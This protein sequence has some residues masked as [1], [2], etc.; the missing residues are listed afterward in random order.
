MKLLRLEMW[1]CERVRREEADG[2]LATHFGRCPLYI[3]HLVTS[4]NTVKKVRVGC[5]NCVL[6]KLY[7]ASYV[8]GN[9]VLTPD[10]KIQFYV[11]KDKRVERIIRDHAKDL[12]SVEEVDHREVTLTPRQREAIRLLATGQASNITRLAEKLGISKPAALRLVKRSLRKLA[13]I[14][15]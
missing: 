15:G 4:G 2:Y 14:H 3:E 10:G 9:P 6:A 5:E 13:R 1:Q 11:R 8:V 12:I 7:R